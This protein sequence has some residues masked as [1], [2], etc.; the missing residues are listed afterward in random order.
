M[1]VEGDPPGFGAPVASINDVFQRGLNKYISG[2]SR[3]IVSVLAANYTLPGWGGNRWLSRLA[4]D[5]QIGA[6]LQY[7]SGLPI[8]APF[9]QSSGS[10]PDQQALNSYLLRNLP[11][12]FTNTTY[13]NRVP[14]VPLFTV[15]QNCHCYDPNTTFTLNSNAW[16]NPGP[17]QWGT[18]AAY[19]N[20]YRYQ[21]RPNESMSFGRLFRFKEKAS[22][23]IRAEFSNVFNRA[24]LPNPTSTNAGQSQARNAAGQT[25]SGFGFIN[26][27]AAGT[28]RQGTIVGRLRF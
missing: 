18:S 13:A 20:D 10:G 15:D 16:Q 11:G 6:M 26:T 9:A 24:V 25:V 21:R 19:Y 23:E 14:G 3:P 4:R 1:G 8:R 5:W 7:S 2:Y 17:G 27:K 28:P 12:G 22:L